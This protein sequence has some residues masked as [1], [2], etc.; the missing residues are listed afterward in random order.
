MISPA[1]ARTA[2][3]TGALGQDGQLLAGRLLTCGYRVIGLT[4]PGRALPTDGTLSEMRLDHTS[5]DDALALRSLLESIRPD[6]IYHLA[7]LHHSS[8]EGAP[9]NQLALQD[10]MLRQNFLA[11]KNL[12]FAML[13]AGLP[14]HLVFAASSQMYQAAAVDTTITELTPRNPA[15]FYGHA[16]SWSMD[17]LAFLRSHRGLRASSAILFNHESPLRGFQFVSRKITRAAAHAK[18]GRPVQLALQNLGSRVDWSSARDVAGAMHQMAASTT[19]EDYVVASGE[20]HS[21]QDLLEAAFGV[22]DL[23]WRAYVQPAANQ[24]LPA[25]TGSPAKLCDMLGWRP[26]VSFEDM[27]HE[28]VLYDLAEH[29]NALQ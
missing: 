22:V 12:A 28:M 15:T 5:L 6:E 18:Q 23:D 1:A 26:S 9:G 21:V 4:K 29:S 24:V 14:A 16:K 25:L 2:L 10:A 7:A 8:Q 20:L 19:G 13:E 17:L 3:I 11:T 27:I